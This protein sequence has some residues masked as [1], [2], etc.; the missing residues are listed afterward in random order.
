MAAA[1]ADHARLREL[2]AEL[3]AVR[4]EREDLEGAWLEATEVLEG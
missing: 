4:A 3:T 2:Q 1:A